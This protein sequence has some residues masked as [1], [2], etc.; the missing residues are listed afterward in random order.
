MS[1][2]GAV[3]QLEMLINQ[4]IL[5][6]QVSSM[7]HGNSTAGNIGY[8]QGCRTGAADTVQYKLA[9]TI[10]Q[11]MCGPGEYNTTPAGLHVV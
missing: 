6:R 3:C 5:A 4:D 9:S 2:I 11:A 8:H 7:S 1:L 10:Y